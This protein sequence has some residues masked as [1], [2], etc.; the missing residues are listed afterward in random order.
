MFF[1]ELEKTLNAL[2][3][4]GVEFRTPESRPAPDFPAGCAFPS[5]Y[6][7]PEAHWNH[8]EI[9]RPMYGGLAL[10]VNGVWTRP[11]PGRVQVFLRGA[12]HTEHWLDRETPYALFWLT[13]APD[14]LNLHQTAY[15]SKSGYSQSSQR[16][17]TTSPFA[18]ELWRC[19]NADET[20]RGRFLSLLLAEIGHTLKKGDFNTANYHS[21]VVS[22]VRKYID[23][24]YWKPLTL[25]MLGAMTHYAPPY[26]NAIFRSRTGEPIHAYLARVRMKNAARLLLET[27]HPVGRI[28]RAVG[29]GDPLYFSRT[30]RRC[31]GC[32]PS[33]YRSIHQRT[34]P[35]NPL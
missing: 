10:Y 1:E 16:L 13:V 15:A 23:E 17:H 2:G 4:G 3:D 35:S 24:C 11:D 30:F 8:V 9:I 6:Y 25:A 32:A 7:P 12:E 14:G 34:K 21:D 33:E 26:L 18:E 31:H 19:A 5:P 28:A 27:L 22:Q 29:I 20:D